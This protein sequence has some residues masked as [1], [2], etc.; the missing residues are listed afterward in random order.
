MENTRR[1]IATKIVLKEFVEVEIEM[2]Y[3]V[4]GRRIV[5]AAEFAKALQIA[6]YARTQYQKTTLNQEQKIA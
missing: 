3:P 1:V 5:L 4:A 2:D 6:R